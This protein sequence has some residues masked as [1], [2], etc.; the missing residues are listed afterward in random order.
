M[1]RPNWESNP[2]PWQ[3]TKQQQFLKIE[4]LHHSGVY[5]HCTVWTMS[6][7][8]AAKMCNKICHTFLLRQSHSGGELWELK[9]VH[10]FG[11]KL[12]PKLA[13]CETPYCKS[14]YS[15]RQVWAVVQV[16]REDRIKMNMYGAPDLGYLC[17]A[18][19]FAVDFFENQGKEI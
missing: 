12:W 1:N 11:S 16:I 13:Y 3:M 2:W 4:P 9:L 19:N 8:S 15:E 14:H 5:S 7:N 6:Y 18:S 10:K 17:T